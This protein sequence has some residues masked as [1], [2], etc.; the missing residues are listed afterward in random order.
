MNGFKGACCLVSNSCHF[1][2]SLSFGSAEVPFLLDGCSAKLPYAVTQCG[3]LG[4]PAW[5]CGVRWRPGVCVWC[6]KLAGSGRRAG[7]LPSVVR[8]GSK[9]FIE[10]VASAMLTP[11]KVKCD[12]GKSA[13]PFR[14]CFLC[15][16]I[17]YVIPLQIDVLG[18]P[19]C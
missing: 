1:A 18:K 3:F 16:Q 7:S 17:H 6:P 15:P 10:F 4:S 9:E 11:L 13:E 14:L 12:H 8:E 2:A 5:A 19:G